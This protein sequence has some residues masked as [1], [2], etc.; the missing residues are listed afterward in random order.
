[1]LDTLSQVSHGSVRNRKSMKLMD[2][3]TPC[4]SP[5]Q[6]SSF[7]SIPPAGARSLAPGQNTCPAESSVSGRFFFFSFNISEPRHPSSVSF[8]L[9]YFTF[10]Y[11][12]RSIILCFILFIYLFI[13]LFFG[14]FTLSSPT[15]PLPTMRLKFDSVPTMRTTSCSWSH[16]SKLVVSES[17]VTPC[18]METSSFDL[19]CWVG[20]TVAGALFNASQR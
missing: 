17:S 14:E 8:F 10:F 2:P 12:N 1:V 9:L 4:H 20:Y 15:S 6:C 3:L 7:Y 5:S 18:L 16:D 11:S 19:F 13:Y